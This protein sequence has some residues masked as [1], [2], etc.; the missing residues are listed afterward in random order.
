MNEYN[1]GAINFVYKWYGM[2]LE[3][4]HESFKDDED[5]DTVNSLL[6]K[7]FETIDVAMIECA[8]DDG[9]DEDEEDEDEDNVYARWEKKFDNFEFW[10]RS[11]ESLK[12]RVIFDED[13]ALYP[14]SPETMRKMLID[15]AYF[16]AQVDVR[17][18]DSVEDIR[19]R[20]KAICDPILQFVVSAV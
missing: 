20:I 12:N 16:G 5:F 4:H 13:F 15:P 17:E 2:I 1:E 18:N 8:V 3:V 9:E 7:P 10:K 14:M 19:M 6:F 11:L